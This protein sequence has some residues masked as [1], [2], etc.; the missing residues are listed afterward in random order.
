MTTRARWPGSRFMS[1]E[2][3]SRPQGC[4]QGQDDSACA[5]GPCTLVRE[6]HSTLAS[7]VKIGNV[8]CSV[9]LVRGETTHYHQKKD[10][11][12]FWMTLSAVSCTHSEVGVRRGTALPR[13]PEAS[14][15]RSP[16]W[17]EGSVQGSTRAQL[18]CAW[19]PREQDE[20]QSGHRV[21]A[22]PSRS[23]K[24]WSSVSGCSPR[25]SKEATRGG[26]GG[27]GG[28]VGT[29]CVCL[30]QTVGTAAGDRG[31]AA[32]EGAQD[33]LPNLIHPSPSGGLPHPLLPAQHLLRPSSSQ[34]FLFH[35]YGLIL[36]ECAS[37]ELVRRHV[38]DL[39]ELSHQSASQREVQP[40]AP[41][42]D[43]A[44]CGWTTLPP[45]TPRLAA[46]VG[47][48]PFRAG[49]G[50]P[51]CICRAL[52]RS[53]QETAGTSRTAVWGLTHRVLRPAGHRGSHRHRVFLA[54]AGSVDCAGA[55][56][57]HQVPEDC[58][59]VPR[60]PGREGSLGAGGARGLE[61]SCGRSELQFAHWKR[62]RCPAHLPETISVLAGAWQL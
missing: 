47:C 46:P 41:S 35:I 20:A 14:G 56:G 29:P 3:Y 60:L 15:L 42:A 25:P 18:G 48:R 62:D 28:A 21:W 17:P 59:H 32:W 40:S 23:H 45:S 8:L 22:L 11:G 9:V 61:M 12:E 31:R 49:V 26:G 54:P 33:E 34:T 36:K 7:S 50:S 6:P 52:R 10:K 57:P 51:A 24:A 2:H 38:A 30:T 27:W 16:V 53:G 13:T 39:L 43:L 58:L 37:E 5:H 1:P 4:G 55:P 19:G 44:T